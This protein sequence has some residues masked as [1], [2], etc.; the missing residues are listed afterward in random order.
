ML[1]IKVTYP[2]FSGP[3]NI[4]Q[5][6][7]NNDNIAIDCKFYINDEKI[8]EADYWFVIE[9]MQFEEEALFINKEKIIFLTAEV[10]HK[11]K[12]YDKSYMRSFLDQF[13]EIYTCHDIYRENVHYTTPFLPWMINSNH[14]TSIFSNA[15]RNI[16]WLKENNSINKPKILSVFCSN[17]Q[18]TDDHRLRL[19]FVK[20]IK[21]Y[22]GDELDWYGNGVN[23]VKEKWSGIAPYKYHIVLENQSRNNI[24]TEKLY[25]SFLGL[26]FPIY[27]GAPNVNKYFDKNSME[28]IDIYDYK[29]SIKKIE[30]LILNN[31]WEK[32]VQLIIES[33]NKVLNEYNVFHRIAQI[34]IKN[35]KL[36]TGKIKQIVKLS[37][38]KKISDTTIKMKI[39][40]KATLLIEKITNSIN[41]INNENI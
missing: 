22:F 6:V 2:G 19:K 26:S 28:V 30:K 29:E 16:N 12:Y 40:R 9:D 18:M 24:I 23:A 31:D 20:E 7:G 15:K 10:I 3:I 5:F 17:Q 1:K 33:K 41:K 25:D 21:K 11:K 8:E 32:R 27:Y 4:E 14:G 13:N 35:E 37:S 39:N 34:A 38:I 36:S